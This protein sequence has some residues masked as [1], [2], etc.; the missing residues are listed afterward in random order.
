M[1]TSGCKGIEINIHDHEYIIFLILFVILYTADTLVLSDNPKDFQ[2]MLNVFNEY[3]KKWKLNINTDK[4][5]VMIFG[6]YARNSVI[7]F[8][9]AGNIIEIIKDF[10]YLGVL[11]TKNG[12]FFQHIKYLSSL[13]K[14]SMQ[15]L[16]KRILNL[17]LPVNCQLKLF[18]Q[19]IVPVLLYGSE[20]F[21]F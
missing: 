1:H 20:T 15:L 21:F 3:C 14:K 16:R 18:D 8:Y 7:S 5:K 11:F 17:H 6:D 4:T 2:D 13:A 9:I 12:R 10:K 19:T